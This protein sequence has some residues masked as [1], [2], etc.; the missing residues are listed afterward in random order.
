[1]EAVVELPDARA[2]TGSRGPVDQLL[3][4][5][6]L[7]LVGF[8]VVMIYSSSA[9][10]AQR[11]MEDPAFFLERQLM[12]VGIGLVAMVLCSW[13]G[14]RA[15]ARLA[16]PLLGVTVL[17]LIAVLTPLGTE[18][19]G[20]Q[21]WLRVAGFTVQ[22][23]E[24]AKITLVVWM[25]F[26]MTRKALKIKTFS[27]GFVPHMLVAGLMV[28]LVV[29][30]PDL[31]T[32]ALLG[33]VTLVMLFVAG[34]RWLYLLGAIAA[35]APVL[36][37]FVTTSEYRMAR[38]RAFFDPFGHRFGDGYQITESLLGFGAGGLWGLG[39]GDGRQKLFFLPEAH[40]DFIASQIGEELGFVGLCA[41]VLVYAVIVWRGWRIALRRPGTYGSFLAFGLT[42]LIGLQALLN[43]AVALGVVPT[44]GLNLP[45]VSYG[46][47]SLVFNM[48]AVG[49]LLD[50][51]RGGP[52]PLDARVRAEE[53][54]RESRLAAQE[55]R[56]RPVRRKEAK[57]RPAR[58]KEAKVT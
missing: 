46:G 4:A 49:I 19:N 51:S 11:N 52:C 38:M 27:V 40:N 26:S 39:L 53:E 10:F 34:G 47:S 32:A 30:E 23:A 12:W 29:L 28:G 8:G 57:D 42:A 3:A 44:K 35:A 45:F 36:Y 18:I 17:L 22:P 58:R 50:I 7:L 15:S 55:K 16:Y 48:A 25:A 43:L 56:N 31:G 2:E 9:V 14:F 37:L 5:A 21:R 33:A 24:L 54:A 20:A 1:M 41:V 13:W 6:V